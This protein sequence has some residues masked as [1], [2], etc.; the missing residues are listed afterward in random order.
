M[1]I[2]GLSVLLLGARIINPAQGQSGQSVPT[3]VKQAFA[4]QYAG[5]TGVKWDKEDGAWEASFT[6]KGHSQSA[7]YEATG[8]Q[9]EAEMEIPVAKLPEAVREY[10]KSQHKTIK[11]AAHITDVPT[12]KLYYEAEAGG[13]D[14]LFN[15]EGKP[16]QKI[17]Q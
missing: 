10:M 7:L 13:K 9:T 5:A 1:K 4:R 14:Y 12:G 15:A 2:I 8:K 11:E 16:V 6:L 17:G 3:V